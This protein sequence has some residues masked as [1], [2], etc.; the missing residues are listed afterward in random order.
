VDLVARYVST[1]RRSS[2][3]TTAEVELPPRAAKPRP[4]PPKQAAE[5]DAK[6]RLLA[7][8]VRRPEDAIPLNIHDRE[9]YDLWGLHE[10]TTAFRIAISGK[11]RQ[12][13]RGRLVA[14]ILAQMDTAAPLYA[15]ALR[16]HFLL[17]W[18]DAQI[19]AQTIA[20]GATVRPALSRMTARRIWQQGLQ[21]LAAAYEANTGELF[22]PPEAPS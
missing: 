7:D 2:T 10:W 16:Q 22:A 19:A 14:S 11:G 3:L 20:P 13:E 4:K 5:E 8:R 12:T 6:H 17:G 21:M 1:K 18:S 15:A 9:R